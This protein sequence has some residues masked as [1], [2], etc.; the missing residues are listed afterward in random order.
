MGDPVW[1]TFLNPAIKCPCGQE[2]T[3]EAWEICVRLVQ[4]LGECVRVQVIGSPRSFR[5]PRV[6][7]GMHG[8]RAEELPALAEK[9][10][11]EEVKGDSA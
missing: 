4:Q 11:W 1:R 2:H 10:G 5:V 8:L 9:Y 3:G 7:V 6:F